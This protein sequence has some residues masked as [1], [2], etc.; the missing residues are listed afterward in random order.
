[1]C[2]ATLGEKSGMSGQSSLIPGPS[3]TQPLA[4]FYDMPSPAFTWLC[5][6]PDSP[7]GTDSGCI[8]EF[9]GPEFTCQGMAGGRMGRAGPVVLGRGVYS[10]ME[11]ERQPTGSS[12]D[13]LTQMPGYHIFMVGFE[14]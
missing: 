13:N 1:M 7:P 8:G 2:L 12:R 11:L 5:C 14:I 6:L 10:P 9:A 3:S 4:P